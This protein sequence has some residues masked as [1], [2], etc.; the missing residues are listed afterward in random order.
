VRRRGEIPQGAKLLHP[1]HVELPQHAQVPDEPA[2]PALR[3]RTPEPEPLAV[4][5]R[6]DLALPPEKS[7]P[8]P[9]L[10]MLPAIDSR[11]REEAFDEL[12]LA[13]EELAF[14]E[15]EPE[16]L[17]EVAEEAVTEEAVADEIDATPSIRPSWE[18]SDLF[19][20]EDEPVDAYG[21]PVSVVE[22]VRAEHEEA[23]EEEPAEREVTLKP[24]AAARSRK[25]SAPKS[26]VPSVDDRSKL[27]AEIGCHLLERGRVAVS[28]LQK[29]Y[30]MDFEEATNVLDELQRMGLIGPY[31]G[32][33]RRDILLT[34]EE[35]LEKVASL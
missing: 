25:K 17:A 14:R 27:L 7:E 9:V 22:A 32:G 6:E 24:V 15:P 20:E 30:G 29:E 5:A 26:P 28:M 2:I 12:R 35:W 21:T 10:E 16:A 8:D 33:Q 18:Q 1:P 34:R 23:V 11:E 19:A 3:P 31:L 13:L 4:S